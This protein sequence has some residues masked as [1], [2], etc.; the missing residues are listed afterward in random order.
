MFYRIPITSV[1]EYCTLVY[2]HTLPQCLSDDIERLQE[3]VLSVF[4]SAQ[5]SYSKC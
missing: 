4:S 1:L 2:H 3:R 5:M